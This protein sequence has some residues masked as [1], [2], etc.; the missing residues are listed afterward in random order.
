M[1][2]RPIGGH[3]RTKRRRS[4]WLPLPAA[5]A[6]V[7]LQPGTVTAQHRL[8][9]TGSMALT[10]SYDDNVFGVPDHRRRDVV[11]RLGARLGAAYRSPRLA[12]RARC[13][14]EAEAFRHSP[15]L[16]TSRARQEAG[17]DLQWSPGREFEAAGSASYA[18]THSPGEFAVV[19]G[20]DLRGMDVMSL[21]L[22]RALAHRFSTTGSLSR[23]LGAR[24]RVVVTHGFTQDEIVG[25]LTSATQAA[26]A[27]LDRQVGPVD[28]LSLTYGLRHFTAVGDRSTSH[29]LTLTWARD[30]T[31]QVHL[32]LKAGPRLSG[33]A[34][35]P[36]L[37]ATLRRRFGNGEAALSYMQTEATVIGRP[38]PVTA[39]GLSA[40]FT[41]SFKRTLTVSAGP[42]VLQARGKG[43][44]A[45]VYGMSV[46]LTW[47]L[48]RHLSLTGSHVLNI[49]YGELD[50]LPRGEIVHNT[51]LLRLVAGSV[52]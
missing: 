39:E 20:L 51:A 46:D 19:T 14:R 44:E 31:S 49:Q 37:G 43:L 45:T 17:L 42:S 28:A 13:V 47:R 52:N 5:L 48:S 35:A 40:A 10:E 34:I 33:Q 36:E 41:R 6:L 21:E 11:S 23:R 24:T 50:G 4:A 32:E 27:R 29:A 22:R 7:A 15:E 30:V 12:V 26:T 18:E 8:K 2:E 1:P 9:T 38:T 3:R 25:G 16:N